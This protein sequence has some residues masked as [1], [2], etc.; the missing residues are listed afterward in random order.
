MSERILYPNSTVKNVIFQIIFPNLF[1]MENK[2]SQYQLKIMKKFPIS[3]LIHQQAIPI[4]N[5]NFRSDKEPDD[6]VNQTELTYIQKIW[7]FESNNKVILNVTSNSIDLSS[8][9]HKTYDLSSPEDNFRDAIKTAIDSFL[10]VVEIPIFNRIGLRYIDECEINQMTNKSFNYYYNSCFPLSRFDLSKT[11]SMEFKTTIEKENNY[12]LK[13]IENISLNG[14]K[15]V[16]I[17]DTD[18]FTGTVS[19]SDYLNITD[20]LHEIISEE[21]FSTLKK[22]AIKRMKGE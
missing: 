8:E 13:Y 6:L 5:I 7:R 4:T 11:K 15:P 14:E 9:F 21:F 12:F 3:K 20:H 18:A 16:L 19:S 10:E 1:Y 22:P 17:I 2:I